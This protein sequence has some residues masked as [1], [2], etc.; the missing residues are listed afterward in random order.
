MTRSYCFCQVHFIID[1]L[2]NRI[3][4]FELCLIKLC[5]LKFLN[6]KNAKRIYMLIVQLMLIREWHLLII[7]CNWTI[8]KCHYETW[9]TRELIRSPKKKET[10]VF[11]LIKDMVLLINFTLNNPC[12]LDQRWERSLFSRHTLDDERNGHE[13]VNT[14]DPV[15][16]PRQAFHDDGAISFVYYKPPD[17]ATSPTE[18]PLYDRACS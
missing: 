6:G 15:L 16:S 3:F 1:I 4:E 10:K 9:Q 11:T 5:Y 14:V 17:V 8:Y 2:P 12:K 7:L 18:T 13:R